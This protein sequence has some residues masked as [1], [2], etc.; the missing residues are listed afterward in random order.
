MNNENNS[1][2][3]EF[4]YSQ[5]ITRYPTKALSALFKK[6][7]TTMIRDLK[8]HFHINTFADLSRI[9]NK[10][11]LAEE[12]YKFE[13]NI[14]FSILVPLYNTPMEYL[15]EM[16]Q[17]VQNQTYKN[18]ELCLADG[19]DETHSEVGITVRQLAEKDGRI[20]Y[21][22]LNKNLGISE[23]TNEC[24]EM[25]TGDFI[26]LF[27]HDD[28]LHP[29]AL[30][31][32]MKAICLENADFIYTDEVVFEGKNIRKIITYH[33][34]PDFA[35]E[36]LRANNYICHFSVF[37]K[38]LLQKAGIFR[39]CFDG[40]QDHDIILRLTAKAKKVFHIRKILYFWRSHSNS[41]AKDISSKEYAIN[42]GVNAVRENISNLGEE[43]IVRSSEAYPTIY[44]VNYKITKQPK[45]S[46][47]LHGGCDFKEDILNTLSYKNL[48]ILTVNKNSLYELNQIANKAT[49]EYLLF[50]NTKTKS[51]SN[52]LV[53]EL[54]MHAQ[55]SNIGAVG[56]KISFADG[57]IKNAGFILGLGPDSVAFT[58]YFRGESDTLG[59]IG[60][61]YFSQNISAVSKDL[62]L[63]KKALFLEVGG[64]DTKYKEAYM[65]VDL[66]LKLM[67]KGY[68]NIFNPYANAYHIEN[69]N[70]SKKAFSNGADATIFKQKWQ[71]ELSKG[72]RYYNP[73]L[74]L[75]EDYL[76]LYKNLVKETKI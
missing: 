50:L 3:K 18:W 55:R 49:G 35:P 25:A 39:S 28:Y 65:D 58:P 17:S 32:N 61:L 68:S 4:L 54:L 57:K 60:R 46:V 38:E 13:K 64:Y 34:K 2:L 63:V 48:E 6:G 53:E 56:G 15:L 10:R 7:P 67:K 16:I 43:C 12:N 19:S 69:S 8:N 30:F 27:D 72:D 75:K 73:K 47:I 33:L 26:A 29:S 31:E 1:K 44:R 42:S 66:C 23:N 41:V 59:Y 22:K 9:S 20:I 45:V 36:N 70:I 14:K 37:K 74:S 11:R 40:S 51:L 5:K 62:M 76:V 24:I 52:D 21:K 71:S